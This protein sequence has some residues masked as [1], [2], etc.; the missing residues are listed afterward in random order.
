VLHQYR[1]GADGALTKIVWG[2]VATGIRPRAI[3]VAP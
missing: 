2:S 3:A 1:I